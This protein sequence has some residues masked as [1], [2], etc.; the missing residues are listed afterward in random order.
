[1]QEEAK[2]SWNT[3]NLSHSIEWI[4]FFHREIPNL[5][6]KNCRFR[7][8]QR[9]N[10]ALR[11]RSSPSPRWINAFIPSLL[12]FPEITWSE[13]SVLVVRLPDFQNSWD[14][15]E[16]TRHHK[17]VWFF[18]PSSTILDQWNKWFSSFVFAFLYV[19]CASQQISRIRNN[20]LISEALYSFS[21]C[22]TAHFIIQIA[23]INSLSFCCCCC[24]CF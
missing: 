21:R 10:D 12:C 19:F 23:I 1:M 4:L 16:E 8:L 5:K 18:F 14:P 13:I 9:G 3:H 22:L 24:C 15:S 17:V 2:L 20:S 7:R 6:K 11:C